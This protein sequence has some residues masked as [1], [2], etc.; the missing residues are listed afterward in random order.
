M[1]KPSLTTE[2]ASPQ[3]TATMVEPSAIPPEKTPLVMFAAGSLIIPFAA[4]EEAFE[5][6]YPQIDLLAE[7]H[8]SIQVMRHVTELHEAI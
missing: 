3:P 7:Y 5:A 8:G 4:V 1:E 6:R 2:V